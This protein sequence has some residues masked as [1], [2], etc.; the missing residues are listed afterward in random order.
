MCTKSTHHEASRAIAPEHRVLIARLMAKFNSGLMNEVLNDCE[1]LLQEEPDHPAALY[2]LVVLAYHHGRIKTAVEALTRAHE[3]YPNEALYTEMLAVLYAMAGNLADATYFAKLS[4]TRGIDE[5]TLLLLPSSLPSFTQSLSQIKAKPLLASAEAQEAARYHAAAAE[6]YERHLV[7][8]PD[9]AAALHGLARCLLA[10]G[11]PGQAMDFLSNLPADASATTASLYG[12]VWTALGEAGTA[13]THHR[14]AMQIAP[15]DAVVSCAA[16]CDAVL[17]P[18]VTAANLANMAA[19]LAASLQ[20]REPAPVEPLVRPPVAIGWLVSGTR[21]VRDLAVVSAL[22]SALNSRRFKPTFYGYGPNDA[23]LN[24]PLRNCAGQWRDIS[25]CDPHTLAEIIGGDGIDVLV[26]IGGHGAPNHIT[27][28]ALG[29]APWQVSWLGNPSTLGLAGVTELADEHEFTVESGSTRRLPLL[30]GVYC[31]DL[32]PPLRRIA[33]HRPPTF[34]ADI[35]VAQLHP[36]LLAAWAEIF[37]RVPDGI[38]ALRDHGF[39]EAGLIEPLSERFRLAGLAERVDIISGDGAAF[40]DQVDVMLAP[41][42]EINPHPAIEALA[43]GVP[44]LALA[45]KGRHRRQ[46]AALLRR[47]SLSAFAFDDEVDYVTAAVCLG[48]SADARAEAFATIADA[49][50]EAPLFR[51]KLV[52]AGFSAA[53]EALVGLEVLL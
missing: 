53:I 7:F 51:P 13:E 9:D 21:D 23:P 39:L 46:S 18:A 45:G 35:Q 52:A 12:A 14:R 1:I 5:V 2:G 44:V 33:A 41:F 48:Q 50:A 25:E 10:S 17:A 29:A 27:A 38:L 3:L 16:L 11:Q 37:T 8:F 32:P 34:G 6:L 28:L 49:L 15:D 36:D 20:A 40:Y 24:A 22:V 4:M 42:V 19:S 47:N 43:Q 31:R 30:H 26:D